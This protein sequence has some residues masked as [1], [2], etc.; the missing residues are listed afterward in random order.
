MASLLLVNYE[1][2]QQGGNDEHGRDVDKCV[3]GLASTLLHGA[4]DSRPHPRGALVRDLVERKEL[5]L[6]A[7]RDERC[8]KA[9]GVALDDTEVEAIDEAERPELPAPSEPNIVGGETQKPIQWQESKH[10]QAVEDDLLSCQVLSVPGVALHQLAARERSQGHLQEND[11]DGQ[12]LRKATK[13]NL[14]VGIESTDGRD[15]CVAVRVHEPQEQH[16]ERMA[17]L[18]DV[19]E[20]LQRALPR[21]RAVARARW[22]RRSGAR[23]QVLERVKREGEP[24]ATGQHDGEAVH[25]HHVAE[26]ESQWNRYDDHNDAAEVAHRKAMGGDAFHFLVKLSL[27]V[28]RVCLLHDIRLLRQKWQVAVVEH[29]RAPVGY[30]RKYGQHSTE[31]PRIHAHGHAHDGGDGSDERRQHEQLLAV[32]AVV[33]QRSE[34]D[35]HEHL[36]EHRHRDGQR[37]KRRRVQVDGA[38]RDGQAVQIRAGGVEALGRFGR[39]PA[40]VLADAKRCLALRQAAPAL[41]RLHDAVH[42]GLG[43]VP[44]APDRVDLC[45]VAHDVGAGIR[46]P[47]RAERCG[48]EK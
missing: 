36:Q 43:D 27:V 18:L 45:R 31:P 40:A 11:S 39:Q 8:E 23:L 6:R 38:Q 34:R 3:A 32:R 13:V 37:R 20:S 17:Q 21:Q 26:D 28:E 47:R 48:L 5:T 30:V 46:V 1:K 15:H 29:E 14:T 9:S 2:Q 4:D 12:T 24:P 33:S 35:E 7:R 16:R 42:L 41:Q 44:A 22:Q 25:V 19:L 10:Q